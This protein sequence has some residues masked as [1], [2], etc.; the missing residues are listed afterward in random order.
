MG[1]P[2][3]SQDVL[4]RLEEETGVRYDL[5]TESVEYTL[6]KNDTEHFVDFVKFLNEIGLLSSDDLP[7]TPGYPQ[8]RYL[9][10]SE[11]VHQDGRDMTRPTKIADNIYLETNHDSESKMRYTE[12]MVADFILDGDS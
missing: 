9:L 8:I 1:G 7:Y 3:A 5:N 4:K 6:P 10:N 11:A 2:E 12:R